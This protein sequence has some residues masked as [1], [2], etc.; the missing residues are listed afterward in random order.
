M[1][2]IPADAGDREMTIDWF[3]DAMGRGRLTVFDADEMLSQLRLAGDVANLERLS[4][5]LSGRGSA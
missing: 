5:A 3:L 4:S 2:M 1:I